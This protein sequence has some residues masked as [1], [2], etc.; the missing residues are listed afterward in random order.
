MPACK[1][2][3]TLACTAML[4]ACMN[5]GGF[6][7]KQVKV[8]KQQGFVQTDEGWLLAMSSRL[9]FETDQFDLKETIRASTLQLG[10]ELRQV[11]IQKLIIQGHT[12][13]VG[14]EDYN[15]ELSLK[16]AQSVKNVLL[17]KGFT[18]NNITTIGYGSS[19]PVASNSTEEGRSENRRVAVIAVP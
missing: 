11:N 12:D 9:L 4:T 15:K 5:M 19:K 14:R 8:L 7:S 18:P 16:R 1:V 2:M 3:T 6:T 17:E 13:N 10:Q